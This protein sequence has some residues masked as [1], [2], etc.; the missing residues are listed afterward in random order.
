MLD[1]RTDLQR[2][3]A[4]KAIAGCVACRLYANEY[5]TLN[6]IGEAPLAYEM[7]TVWEAHFRLYHPDVF[8]LDDNSQIDEMTFLDPDITPLLPINEPKP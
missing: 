2:L 7:R 8:D 4:T 1:L 3:A 6:F 5:A